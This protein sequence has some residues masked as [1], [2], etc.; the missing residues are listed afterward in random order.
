MSSNDMICLNCDE[1]GHVF[2]N[3]KSPIISYGI[4]GYKIISGEVNYMMIQRKDTMGYT[5]FVRGK[6]REFNKNELLNIFIQEMTPREKKNI[7]TLSFDRIWN[8]MWIC[9]KSGIYITEYNRAKAKFNNLDLDALPLDEPSR[10]TTKEFGFPK[11]RKNSCESCLNCAIREFQEETGFNKNDITLHE[12]IEPLIETFTGSNGVCYTH[13]YYLANVNSNKTPKV[14]LNNQKQMEEVGKIGYY[15]YAKGYKLLR[16]YDVQKKYIL[17]AANKII[18][19][20]LKIIN[21]E[22][23]WKLS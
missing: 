18:L 19:K 1:H 13:V 23:A 14:N 7:R 8:D 4:I 10:Y 5:D 21:R 12:D 16:D 20:K 9:K 17:Y 11:G 3:C 6:Y 22:S 2:K 15:N